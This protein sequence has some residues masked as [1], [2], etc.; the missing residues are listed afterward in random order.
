MSSKTRRQRKAE[1]RAALVE[2]A[3]GCFAARGY[4][5]TG[6][7]DIAA[8]AGVAHGTFYVHFANKDAVLDELLGEFNDAFVARLGPVFAVAASAPIASTVR[9][10]AEAFLDHWRRHRAFV[11]C[12]AARSAAGLDVHNLRDGVNPPMARLIGASLR[13]A[14]ARRGAIGGS[15]ELVTHGLLAMWM[16]VGM[17]FLFNN[18]VS[19]DQA[20]DTLVAMSV[21]AI[22]AVLPSTTAHPED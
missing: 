19:R 5:D 14:A 9:A 8:A 17:Q 12:Y 13:A 3:R 1:P 2:A 10:T 7:A 22:E 21:G 18:D 4:A 11:E 6:I 16:R 15:W 20:V